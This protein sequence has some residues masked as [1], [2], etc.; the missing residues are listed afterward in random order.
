MPNDR[1][2]ELSAVTRFLAVDCAY[3]M[4]FV[5]LDDGLDLGQLFVQT[6]SLPQAGSPAHLSGWIDRALATLRGDQGT[7]LSGC[8][9]VVEGRRGIIA[10]LLVVAQAGA[11]RIVELA[12][13]PTYQRHGIGTA[14]VAA[15]LDS[16]HGAQYATVA[17]TVIANTL[18]EH[19]LRTCGFTSVSGER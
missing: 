5:G 8:S 7:L 13:A 16:L 3:P 14:L 15:T 9:W 2:R 12:V 1:T 18:H 10:A 6:T 19:L 17:A 11:P 4:R